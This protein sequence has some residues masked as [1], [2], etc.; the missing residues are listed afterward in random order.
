MHDFIIYSR[1]RSLVWTVSEEKLFYNICTQRVI[2]SACASKT[3]CLT[4]SFIDL[5]FQ[6][7]H[8]WAPIILNRCTLIWTFTGLKTP[9]TGFLTLWLIQWNLRNVNTLCMVWNN[10][11]GSYIY[12]NYVLW[13][14]NLL[15]SS[16]EF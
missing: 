2:R 16:K 12:V 1:E 4:E 9:R 10:P 15:K 6:R 5:K 14:Q 7:K 8:W 13:D 3:C 11:V